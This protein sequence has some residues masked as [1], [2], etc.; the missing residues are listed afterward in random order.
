L[1]IYYSS[2]STNVLVRNQVFLK[3]GVISLGNEELKISNRNSSSYSIWI[4]LE[5][6]TQNGKIRT[7]FQF[8]EN[9]TT[10]IGYDN[11]GKTKNPCVFALYIDKKERLT[12]VDSTNQYFIMNDF[13]PQKWTNVFINIFEM[14]YYEFYING[15]LVNTFK[16]ETA[17]FNKPDTKY[18]I[19]LGGDADL[20]KIIISNFKRWA[21][22]HTHP[23]VWSNYTLENNNDTYN[24]K[25]SLTSYDGTY[26]P[27]ILSFFE[28]EKKEE[29]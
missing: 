17:V 16:R 21:Y 18:N 15:K 6:T 29:L 23:T 8:N 25:I 20:P 24:A 12:F 14:E 9:N 5:D 7:I 13:P 4:Y 10:F 27:F 3:N 19:V 1:Y 11:N 22:T 26:K 2:I 28:S